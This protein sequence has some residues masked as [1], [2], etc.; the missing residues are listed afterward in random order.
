MSEK[1]LQSPI[2]EGPFNI[3]F[4][5]PLTTAEQVADHCGVMIVE[6]RIAAGE[7]L[8]EERLA[9][10]CGVSRGPVREALRIL[11]RRRLI[12][13]IPRRGAFVRSVSL[14]SIA[15][16]FNVR[17]ALAAMAAGTMAARIA[18]G[19]GMEDLGRLQRRAEKI[20]SLTE[21]L[22]CT[23]LDYSFQLTRFVF[24]TIIGSANLIL[25]DIWKELNE[26][27]FWTTIWKVPQEGRTPAERE[28]RLLQIETV[29]DRISAGD[30]RQAEAE[31]RVTLDAIRDRV[32]NNL[33][34]SRPSGIR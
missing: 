16:L 12:E 28:M 22:S 18:A 20:K 32:L 14:D 26:N 7:R 17:N 3:P 11:E 33:R 8:G 10:M 19:Q 24:A 15:D 5:R 13:I 2:P 9:E 31:M 6:G 27:T 29:L 25:I 34:T 1:I 23:S 21:D 4:A 30:S